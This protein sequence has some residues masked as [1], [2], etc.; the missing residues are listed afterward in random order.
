MSELTILASSYIA[1]RHQGAIPVELV[2]APARRIPGEPWEQDMAPPSGSTT[3]IDG[4]L[5]HNEA[6]TGPH[7][8]NLSKP[9]RV[10]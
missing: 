5:T 1:Q 3:R 4:A 6:K 2:D 10:R 9:T 7:V 8:T